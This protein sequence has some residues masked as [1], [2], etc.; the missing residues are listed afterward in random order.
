MGWQVYGDGGVWWPLPVRATAHSSFHKHR[1]V[2]FIVKDKTG[3]HR[4]TG[5]GLHRNRELLLLL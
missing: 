1:R 5:R 4:T 3:L 2:E